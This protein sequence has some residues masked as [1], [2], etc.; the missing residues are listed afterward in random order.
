M[1]TQPHSSDRDVL[2]NDRTH[3]QQFRAAA[4]APKGCAVTMRLPRNIMAGIDR[5]AATQDYEPSRLAAI[6]RLLGGILGMEPGTT[7]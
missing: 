2:V 3:G 7:S 5:F 1:K 4:D 6:R